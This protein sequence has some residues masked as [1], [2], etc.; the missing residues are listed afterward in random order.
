[1]DYLTIIIATLAAMGVVAMA[2]IGGY[3]V[4]SSTAISAERD[5]AD[6]R[7]QGLLASLNEKKP[8]LRY[9]KVDARSVGRK[10]YLNTKLKEVA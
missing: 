5:F 7:I 2:W 3:Q 9:R 4:G 6:R 1:M 8:R 10:R